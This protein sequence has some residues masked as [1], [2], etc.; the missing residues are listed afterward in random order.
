MD[1]Q[2]S[3]LANGNISPCTYKDTCINHPVGC[4]GGSWWC[5]RKANDK[6][7]ENGNNEKK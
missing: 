6:K 3:F 2:L 7:E 1:G 4:H 5:G